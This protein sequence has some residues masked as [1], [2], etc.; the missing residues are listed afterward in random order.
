MKRVLCVLFLLCTF[1]I[2]PDRV[3]ASEYFTSAYD[4]TYSVLESGS[5]HA[6]MKVT[7]TNTTKEYYASSYKVQVGFEH[8]ENLTARDPDGLLSPKLTKVDGGSII[9][10]E[11]N[12]RVVG[13][14]SSLTYTISFDTPD[15]AK[16]DGGIWEINIPG[17]EDPDAFRS[18]TAHVEVPKN[19]GSPAYIKPAQSTMS[20]T[21]TK[22]QLG[23]S[24]IS[25]AYGD[26]QVYGFNLFYHLKNSNLF[27]VR[28]EIA[29][30]P[31]T[32]YQEVSIEYMQPKPTN[33]T[34][35]S[36][37]NWLASYRLAP[38]ERIT[39]Q[40]R[41]TARVRLTP[42]KQPMTKKQLQVYLK[43]QPYWETSRSEITKLAK[44]LKTPRAIYEYLVTNLTYDFSRVEENKV[45]LG[46]LGTLQ[47]KNSA[48][49]LEFTDLFITLAR[50]AGI[51]AREVDGYAN[52][53]NSRQRPLSLVKDILH[54]W[55]E[56][57]DTEKQT[58]VMIDPTWGNTTG[59]VDYFDVLDFDHF[60][61]VI[62]GEDSE[63]PVPA[64]GYKYEEDEN[65]KDVNVTFPRFF[66]PEKSS[67]SIEVASHTNYSL[68]PIK[69]S[70]RVKN[71]GS[72][73]I[74]SQKVSVTAQGLS[75]ESQDTMI[76]DIPPFGYAE[77][78]LS[79]ERTPFLTNRTFPLT[80]TIAG[81]TIVQSLQVVP[82]YLSAYVLAGGLFIAIL[83]IIILIITKK[84]RRIPVS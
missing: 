71:T 33:V 39:V 34:I 58:W 26:E 66:T 29:L 43:E 1:L 70:L 74:T 48:V 11:F 37:G 49:C 21:F 59:G 77:L 41:G 36:D 56:Y 67:V 19:F 13:E 10:A 78:P 16:K 7:L 84:P 38:S 30:P 68:L 47:Q 46:G 5:T 32:N 24:G 82:L 35:D 81:V 55:P 54:A 14:G 57:Y 45:R 6:T 44:E 80:I 79:Y 15:V 63:Y 23:K 12:K 73:V 42:K 64:G 40:T 60:A 52:T 50:A 76:G 27:P 20:T 25:I 22:E 51:P 69:T 4:V 65:L 18:F 3:L 62:R 17:L 72:G 83:T 9:E 75:P 28:T 2:L 8:I 61:F 31:D 53:E